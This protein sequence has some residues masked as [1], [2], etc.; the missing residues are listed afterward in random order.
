M[1]DDPRLKEKIPVNIWRNPIYFIACC[2]GVGL[3][4]VMPGTYAT[5][6]AIPVYYGLSHFSL[7]TYIIITL[8]ITAIA[9]YVSDKMSK[10]IGIHDHPGMAIDEVVGYLW[11]MIAVPAHWYTILIGFALF[12]LF[13]I[14]KPGPIGWVDRNVHGGFGIVVDD[15][16]AAVPT[17]IILQ[18][19]VH[20]V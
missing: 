19:I 8:L 2:F 15:I 14:W 17:W 1:K 13:D 18:I 6:F 3:L 11:A 7:L 16:A 5:I 10:D 9:M 12:R 20:F 4:P